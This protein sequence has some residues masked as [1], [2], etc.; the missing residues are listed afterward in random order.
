MQAAPRDAICCEILRPA[1]AADAVSLVARA[2]S[3]DEPMSVAVGV[4]VAEMEQLL[5]PAAEQIV[6]DGLTVVARDTQTGE[7]AGVLVTDDFAAPLP[8]GAAGASPKF[9]PIFA[10][11]ERL[12][13]EYRQ[14]R[15]VSRGEY[16][17]LF[18]LATEARYR[19]RG[20]AGRLVRACLENGERLRYRQALTE[21]TGVVSQHVFLGAGFA[22]RLHAAYR[23][24][25]AFAGIEG[26][27]AT[28][29]MDGA[30]QSRPASQFSGVNPK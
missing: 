18:M 10:L 6:A 25:P 16:L 5:L 9:D 29:L 26:H 23:D 21:A 2:F 1:D 13:E 14:D 8:L 30:V 27:A 3:E 22:E 12:D 24:I 20:V 4:T 11:L 19:G 15:S 7:M 17:H 28:I